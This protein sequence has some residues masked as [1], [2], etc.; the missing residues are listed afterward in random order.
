M[1]AD[2]IDTVITLGWALLA[3]VA[4]LAAVASIVLLAGTAVGAWAVRGLWRNAVR[5]A[6][7]RSRRRAR[8]VARAN[9]EYDEA[10]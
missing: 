3:W 9:R 10:A 5:P 6:W 7:A 4:V 1:I 2:A 8:L